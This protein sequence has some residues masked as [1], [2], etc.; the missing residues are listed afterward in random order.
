MTKFFDKSK[1]PDKIVAYEYME[2]TEL[3]FIKKITSVSKLKEGYVR[4][5]CEP[6]R[7]KKKGIFSYPKFFDYEG[8]LR[9]S[10]WLDDKGFDLCDGM[11]FK[12]DDIVYE[13]CRGSLNKVTIFGYMRDAL[14]AALGII[15]TNTNEAF[16]FLSFLESKGAKLYQVA[17]YTIVAVF[18]DGR[19]WELGHFNYGSYLNDIIDIVTHA[20]DTKKITKEFLVKNYSKLEEF[21]KSYGVYNHDMR[22]EY[23][24]FKN[25]NNDKGKALA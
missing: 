3:P 21:A 17:Q 11:Y 5:F 12:H 7:A 19:L 18:P 10:R 9:N 15:D 24:D 23:E 22:N 13:I 14:K 2:D 1:M 6:I 16:E 20:V 25:R 8:E 4:F